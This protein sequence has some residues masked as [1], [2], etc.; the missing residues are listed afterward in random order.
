MYKKIIN[1]Y[2]KIKNS[3]INKKKIKISKKKKNKFN[4]IKKNG[5]YLN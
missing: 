5:L 1:K 3:I 4:L 2:L